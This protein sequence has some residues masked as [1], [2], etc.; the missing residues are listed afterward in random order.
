MI[1]GRRGPATVALSCEVFVFPSYWIDFI[2]RNALIGAIIEI[3]EA[4]D[5]SGLDADLTILTPEQSLDEAENAWPGIGVAKDGYVPVGGC[6]FGS[7][8]YYY[9][10]A[11][12]GE[13]G[14]L[15][16]IYHDAV[17]D[18]GYHPDDAI[19]LVLQNYQAL[20]GHVERRPG[21]GPA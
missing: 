19:A 2:S 17:D 5:H 21:Q 20:L 13:A 18:Q 14:P 7:G 10:R 11:A 3:P 8:D 6:N 16:R 9:I 15:Y 4:L 12:D 1:C